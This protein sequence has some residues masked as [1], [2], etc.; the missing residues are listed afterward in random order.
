MNLA[1]SYS[2]IHRFGEKYAQF[3]QFIHV[4]FTELVNLNGFMNM[5]DTLTQ[6]AHT[7]HEPAHTYIYV[8]IHLFREQNNHIRGRSDA[9]TGLTP[10]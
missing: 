3:V 2:Y 1:S 8:F 7:L 9:P 6:V 4:S 5:L 10:A